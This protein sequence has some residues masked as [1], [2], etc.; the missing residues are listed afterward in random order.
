MA[1]AVMLQLGMPITDVGVVGADLESEGSVSA[2]EQML[3]TLKK[4]LEQKSQALQEQVAR[5][6]A[7]ISQTVQ[8]LQSA[9]GQL[10]SLH[11]QMLQEMREQA[12]ELAM[13]IAGKVLCQQI[14]AKAYDIDPIVE[15][16]VK[17][18]PPRGEMSVRLSPEDLERSKL[19]GKCESSGTMSIQFVADPDVPPG[20]CC[21]RSI[22]GAVE[23]DPQTSL[24]QIGQ[25]LRRTE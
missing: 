14:D 19:A 17:Q 2:A 10:T 15:E 11:E 23:T 13:I 9:A 20:G 16:A 3:V 1:E 21:V 18:L 8:T 12:V 24:D 7:K 5:E 22:E 6:R 4:E 25:T